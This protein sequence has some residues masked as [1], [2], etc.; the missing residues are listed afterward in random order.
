MRSDLQLYSNNTVLWSP[1]Q[2]AW[3]SGCIISC[4]RSV[5]HKALGPPAVSWDSTGSDLRN[6]L[7]H[8]DMLGMMAE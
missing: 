1:S 4:S 2:N 3:T 6:A 5:L 8:P 7:G